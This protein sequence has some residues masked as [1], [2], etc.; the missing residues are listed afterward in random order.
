MN[1]YCSTRN[2]CQELKMKLMFS[3]ALFCQRVSFAM[4]FLSVT[5]RC[6]ATRVSVVDW[7][8]LHQRIDGSAA[9]WCF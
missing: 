3:Y 7:N 9:A 2:I 8:N 4:L 5:A 1:P 6:C